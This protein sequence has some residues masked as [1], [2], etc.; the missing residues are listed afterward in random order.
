MLVAALAAAIGLSAVAASFAA[1]PI[2]E[3]EIV[4]DTDPDFCG[5]G[6]AIEIEGTIKLTLWLGETGGDPEQALR[7]HLNIHLTYTNPDTGDAVVE[8]WSVT[9]TNEIVSGLESGPH[10][11]EFVENGLKATYRLVNGGLLTRDAGS[12]TYRVSFDENDDVTDFEAITIH[13]P[14]P[15]FTS[16]GDPFCDTLVP[17][18]GLS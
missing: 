18:L 10:T 2:R 12:L 6:A 11:H 15:N 14:H 8:R 5:T 4:D 3:I 13:G 9:R 1:P 16:E 7:T 17:A